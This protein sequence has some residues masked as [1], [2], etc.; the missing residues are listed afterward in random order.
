[1][2]LSSSSSE[3]A[4]MGDLEDRPTVRL[5]LSF[6]PRNHRILSAVRCAS[7]S[8]R[9][10]LQDPLELSPLNTAEAFIS[11]SGKSCKV[12][13]ILF[14]FALAASADVNEEIDGK[15]EE[16]TADGAGDASSSSASSERD[17]SKVR[18]RSPRRLGYAVQ[19]VS[20]I[21]RKFRHDTAVALV[22]QTFRVMPCL[23]LLDLAYADVTDRVFDVLK[24]V[25]TLATLRLVACKQLV[26]LT[27]GINQISSLTELDVA[28]CQLKA[29]AFHGLH[30]PRLRS[31]SITYCPD[32]ESFLG[33][34][35]ETSAALVSLTVTLAVIADDGF[36]DLLSHAC[37]IEFLDVEST[38][39]EALPHALPAEGLHSI[40]KLSLS[41]TSIESDVLEE[42]LAYVQR[43]QYLGLDGCPNIHNL[44]FLRSMSA[45][46]RS[47]L[48][49]LDLS[50][51][52]SLVSLDELSL[53]RSLT[54]LR[55]SGCTVADNLA[56]ISGLNQIVALDLSMSSV[57]DAGVRNV[58][59]ACP[60]SLRYLFL[61]NCSGVTSVN[62]IAS[63]A[64]IERLLCSATAL[65]SQGITA[66]ASSSTLVE[67]DFSHTEVS[68]VNHLVRCLQLRS[69]NIFGAAMGT[70][71]SGFA[72]LVASG[73]VEVISEL[74]YGSF[75]GGA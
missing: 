46:A 31:L 38:A 45:A 47:Q 14:P 49:S 19:S 39:I 42:T 16:E 68:D 20:P 51:T 64:K 52:D 65:Q 69:V 30:L 21:G 28:R 71:S 22:R 67:V 1:M 73:R 10:A 5:L 36:A 58:A 60:S 2:P 24:E 34:S 57:T 33:A 54:G 27:P 61:S 3:S 50:N 75:Q 8:W 62:A 74:I 72:Q 41:Y 32:V 15:A 4:S 29:E 35:P 43:L 17:S 11:K 18:R 44:R 70:T 59:N 6:V 55:L 13:N 12:N 40:R 37:N 66:L 56:W 7:R 48:T 23:L 53:L 9:A 25:S 63:C 26:V